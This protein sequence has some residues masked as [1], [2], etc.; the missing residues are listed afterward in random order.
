METS[1]SLLFAAKQNLEIQIWICQHLEAI[2]WLLVW[3]DLDIQ[4]SIN[5]RAPI[6]LAYNIRLL[7]SWLDY[8]DL[9]MVRDCR[10]GLW[11][12]T[13]HKRLGFCLIDLYF[14]EAQYFTNFRGRDRDRV[15]VMVGLDIGPRLLVFCCYRSLV[16]FYFLCVPIFN[17]QLSWRLFHKWF[18]K[19]RSVFHSCLTLILKVRIFTSFM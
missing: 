5:Y 14:H 1:M 9:C 7:Q 19:F 6:W 17:F 8:W 3:V 18:K 10:M 13:S 2:Y 11:R 15:I 4:T 16:H 12:T